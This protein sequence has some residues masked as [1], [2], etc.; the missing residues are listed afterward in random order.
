MALPT[1]GQ[2]F[3][4]TDSGSNDSI[5]TFF[6]GTSNDL[7]DYKKG[8]SF[9]PT[10]ATYA[11]SNFTY[12]AGTNDGRAISIYDNGGV[13][14]SLD[15]EANQNIPSGTISS[16]NTISLTD[17]YGGYKIVNPTVTKASDGSSGVDLISYAA[18]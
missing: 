15:T 3:L 6:S 4:N 2:I 17:F 11:V 1:S 13:V 9:V 7:T 16:S 18:K 14:P 8:G 12:I 5:K 10:P